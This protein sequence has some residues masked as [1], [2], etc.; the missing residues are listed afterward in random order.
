MSIESVMP[1]NYLILC[2]PLI[3]LSSI[4]PSN[5]NFSNESVICIR[6]LNFGVSASASVLPMNTQD[7]FPLG[8]TGLISLMSKRLSGVFSSTTV[9]KQQIFGAQPSIDPTPV[10]IHDYWKNH[11]LDYAFVG[12]VMYLLFNML[13]RLVSFSSKEQVSFNFMAAVTIC[14]DFGAQEDKVSRCFHCFPIYLPWSD[15]TGCRD[16]D[17]LNVEF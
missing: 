5:R 7:W 15:G 3:L 10:S 13:S 16:L 2:H 14:S 4:F 12:K 6:W 9:W 8:W 17:F 1:S 11:N